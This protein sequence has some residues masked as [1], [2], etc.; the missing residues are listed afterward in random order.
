MGSEI[1]STKKQIQIGG[2]K[3]LKINQVRNV[4]FIAITKQEGSE[5]RSFTLEEVELAVK[6]EL[7]SEADF[8]EISSTLLK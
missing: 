2:A 1:N 4:V 8:Q 6:L 5:M 7:M 3:M